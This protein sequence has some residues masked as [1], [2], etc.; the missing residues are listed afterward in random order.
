MTTVLAAPSI[1]SREA[2]L[3][4]PTIANEYV[5]NLIQLLVHIDY[6]TTANQQ[7]RHLRQGPFE[8]RMTE[9]SWFKFDSISASS[10]FMQQRQAG[11]SDEQPVRNLIQ[12]DAPVTV[13]HFRRQFHSAVDRARGKNQHI[14]A[15]PLNA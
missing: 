2:D 3:N 13:G 9:S 6:S 5:S 11:H 1:T 4:D 15:S 14:L 7:R 8:I 12:D 10:C